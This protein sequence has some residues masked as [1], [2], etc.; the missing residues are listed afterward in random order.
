MEEI[1]LCL[2]PDSDEAAAN[3]GSLLYVGV[4]ITRERGAEEM[5]RAMGFLPQNVD[6]RLK[7]IGRLE[8]SNLAESLSRIPGWERTQYVGP[9]GRKDLAIALR[10][11]A[12]GLALLHAEPNYITAQPVKVFE[13]M[14]AGLPVI[15]SDLPGCREIIKT[16]RC[17]LLVN[18]LEPRDI[19]Q[20][21]AHLWA[22]PD[23]AK[24]MG[25]RG[26][27]AVQERYNWASQEKILLRLYQSLCD[28]RRDE[29]VIARSDA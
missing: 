1:R 22:N 20:A 12:A 4:R 7:L 2:S 10:R 16:A 26:F 6:A 24:A 8:P 29:M 11:A 13:Y 27:E 5:V 23:E 19:A 18:P 3:D 15:A 21:I 25:Q 14:C 9:L 28:F 17:G